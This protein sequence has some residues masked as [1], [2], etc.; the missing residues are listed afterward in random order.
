MQPEKNRTLQ[1]NKALHKWL[2]QVADT[3]NDAGI[4]KKAVFAVKQ[5]DV[6][7][8]KEGVKEDLFRPIYEAMT[9]KESTADA[10][11]VEYDRVCDVLAKHLA[12]HFGVTLPPFPNRYG[13]H[14]KV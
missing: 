6:P 4:G 9:L 5:V 11:T 2:E 8:S 10:N 1:Q 13:L 3:L 7:W 14:E 12:E